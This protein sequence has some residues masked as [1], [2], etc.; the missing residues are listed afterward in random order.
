MRVIR[1][2]TRC[3]PLPT[4][5]YREKPNEQSSKHFFP[6]KKLFVSSINLWAQWAITALM[7]AATG[8]SV[9]LVFHLYVFVGF[10]VFFWKNKLFVSI[11]VLCRMCYFNAIGDNPWNWEA[12]GKWVSKNL[13]RGWYNVVEMTFLSN[14]LT[15]IMGFWKIVI[16]R[17]NLENFFIV[18]SHCK[19]T[20]KLDQL[21]YMPAVDGNAS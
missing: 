3:H 11:V 14:D 21:E 12:F 9:Y 10:F 4:T 13:V 8:T 7:S 17:F 20:R 15:S 5:E 1:N 2:P 16:L 6:E 19:I 18:P